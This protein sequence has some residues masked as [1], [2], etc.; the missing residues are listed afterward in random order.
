AFALRIAQMQLD[1]LAGQAFDSDKLGI[2]QHLDAF[3]PEQMKN[4]F[5][6]VR[7]FSRN[8]LPDAFNDGNPASKPPYCLREFESHVAAANYDQ[9]VRNAIQ[10]QSFNVGQR[11]GGFHSRNVGNSCVGPN[12]QKDLIARKHMHAPLIQFHLDGLGSYEVSFTHDQLGAS[13][14][15]NFEVN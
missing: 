2:E 10:F 14:L 12:I 7:I 13:R 11:P 6:D 8:E 4:G 1:V 5:R 3:I 9:V 15:I